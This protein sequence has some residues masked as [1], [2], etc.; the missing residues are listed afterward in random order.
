MYRKHFGL[1]DEPFT[2]SPDPRFLYLSPSHKEA[3]A[4][5]LYGIRARRGFVALIGEV[6]TGKTTLL[7]HWMSQM[8]EDI[9]VAYVFNT[10]LG[11]DDLLRTVMKEWELPPCEGRAQMLDAIN[12]FLIA[13][14]RAGKVTALVVDEAQNLPVPILEAL[15]MLS[16][17]ETTREKLLQIVLAG[18]PELENKLNRPELRQLKQRISLVSTLKPLSREESDEYIGWRLEVAGYKGPGLFTRRALKHV[19]KASGGIPR[20]INI[21][22]GNALIVGYG[23]NTPDVGAGIMKGVI[24]DLGVRQSSGVR[25]GFRRFARSAAAAVAVLAAGAAA[26]GAYRVGGFELLAEAAGS[27][28]RGA[29]TVAESVASM[30]TVERGVPAAASTG[31]TS[32]SVA[33]LG[34]EAPSVAPTA[35]APPPER[36]PA[37]ATAPVAAVESPTPAM[38]AAP[39]PMPVLSPASAPVAAAAPPTARA[40]AMPRTLAMASP[41][42][43]SG[44]RVA[45]VKTGQALSAIVT[46]AYGEVNPTILDLVRGANPQIRDINLIRATEAIV[47]PDVD[48]GARIHRAD[49]GRYVVHVATVTDEFAAKTLDRRLSRTG[50]KVYTIPVNVSDDLVWYRV[51]VGDFATEDE[52]RA[53]GRASEKQLNLLK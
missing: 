11:F 52:A 16:N 46:A 19:W 7:R 45:V 51:V 10:D 23:E 35:P 48:V 8:G 47:L 49:D 4:A 36:A 20:L 37:R 34:T 38:A 12:E 5:L 25:K 17:L 43:A 14:L 15:R 41:A 24:R 31:A 30:V 13:Q 42:S 50:R 27:A 21:M 9:T 3:L 2:L 28:M 53:T 26:Y 6:G 1:T 39:P 44:G 18:Q 40:E 29:A 33:T 22:C 32:P